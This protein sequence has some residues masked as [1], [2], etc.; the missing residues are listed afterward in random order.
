MSEF[1]VWVER[2]AT[3]VTPASYIDIAKFGC[4]VCSSLHAYVFLLDCFFDLI[5]LCSS[6]SPS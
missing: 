2:G 3:P 5:H 6:E 1:E 4:A